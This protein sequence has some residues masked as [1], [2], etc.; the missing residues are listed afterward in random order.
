MAQQDDKNLRPRIQFRGSF[1][2]DKSKRKEE[3]P[4]IKEQKEL[5]FTFKFKNYILLYLLPFMR[6]NNKKT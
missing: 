3:C 4:E 5:I 2:F 1:G 6:E